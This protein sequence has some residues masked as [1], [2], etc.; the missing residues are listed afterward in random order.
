[1]ALFQVIVLFVSPNNVIPPP[2]AVTSVGTA[3][4]PIVM[5]LS[6]TNKSCVLIV[7]VVPLTVKLPGIVTVPDALPILIVVA[8][9]PM[10]NVVAFVLNTVAVPTAVVVISAPLT[11]RSPETVKLSA[12]KS[13]LTVVV[14]VLAPILTVVP[15]P[16]MFTVV[17]VVL[18]TAAVAE[19][20]VISPPL[21][22]RSPVNSIPPVTS[23]SPATT[24]SPVV[25]STV[26]FSSPT[27]KPFLT[28][29]YSSAIVHFPFGCLF[30]KDRFEESKCRV[31]VCWCGQ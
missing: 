10:F 11:A 5:F 30:F 1:M 2:A 9:P 13:L 3:T 31:S 28:L 14:P 18:N 27:V 6:S 21:T 7:V 12:T 23:K 22:A 17:A 15:A 16:P 8:A 25:P 20:V 26:N 4:L 19:V 29:K 24:T